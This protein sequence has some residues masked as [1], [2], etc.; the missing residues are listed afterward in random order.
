MIRLAFVALVATTGLLALSSCKV[1]DY[2]LNCGVDD[3]GTGD[4]QG[5]GNGDGNTDGNTG[6]GNGCIN[7]GT[8]VCD[9]KDNDCDGNVDE[10]AL[11]EVGDSCGNGVGECAGGVK[12]CVAGAIVC[13]KNPKPEECN[14]L[15]DDCDGVIDNGD[16][17]GG[18]KC[19]TDQG[20]CSTGTLHCNPTSHTVTCGID[21]GTANAVGCPVGGEM[22]PFGSAE[23]CNG[24]DDDCD[25][26]FDEDV[27]VLGSCSG[28]PLAGDPDA[29]ECQVG[30]LVCDGA[31]GTKCEAIPGMPD[32]QG[33]TFDGCDTKDNDCD[34][35]TDE[36]FHL[37]T[38]PT[39][40]GMCGMV[41]NLPHAFEGCS[42]GNC[43]VLGCEDT[44]HDNDGIAS[45]GCEFGP[46]TI[47]SSV[48]LCNGIDDDCNPATDENNLPPPANLC[49]TLGACAG[50]TAS[51]QGANGFQC[52]YSSDVQT[53]GSGNVVPETSCDGIDNDCD[54][55]IDEGQ[56][57]LDQAC[58]DGET[59]VCKGTGTFQCDP[60]NL[61]GPAICVITD[62]GSSQAPAET[63]DGLDNDCDGK[64]D[65]GADTGNLAGQEWVSI[66]GGG[67]VEIMKYE[68]SQ[69][70]AT[71]T[72][73]GT[74]TNFACSKPNVL[75]WSNVTYPQADAACA[76]IGARLCTEAE[77]QSMCMPRVTY[78]VSGPATAD[79]TDFTFIEA[80]DFF[81]NT[82]IGGASQA[83][84]QVSP[85]AFNGTTFMQV[86]DNGFSVPLIS[87]ALTDSSRL[88]YQ[89]DLE[90]GTDYFIWA[91]LRSPSSSIIAP[92]LGTATAAT[93][94]LAPVSDASTGVGDLVIVVT[95]TRAGNGVPTH[96]LQSGF[97]QVATQGHDDG[98]NDGRFSIAFTI[99][100][101]AG[102]QSYQAYTSSSGTS[103]SGL[104][105]VRAGTFNA[106]N[107]AATLRDRGNSNA[108]N[109]PTSPNVSVDSVAFAIGAW[110]LSSTTTVSVS[111][112]NGFTEL[113]EMSGSNDAELSV[114]S[115]TLS[116]GNVDPGSFGD[117]TGS[118]NGTVAASLVVSGTGGSQSMYVGLTPG[119][120]AGAPST[121]LAVSASN[122]SQWRVTS[123]FTT[124]AAGTYTLSLF[125]REDG[126]LVDTIA[127]SRQG[128]NGPTLDNAWA[129]QSNPRTPQDLTCNADPLDT[130][131]NAGNGDQDDILATGSL[132]MCFANQAGT[133]DAFDMSGNVKEWTQA[134]SP[135]QNPLRGGASNNEVIGTTCQLNFSLA[136]DNFFFPNVGFRC[137]RGP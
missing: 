75:P 127:V 19:G 58:D 103:Y 38:D 30:Q 86:P 26:N 33:P 112:P 28:G 68:A 2:C 120:T 109:P 84:T 117:N 54:G 91:R 80:E 7:T 43:T 132:P 47:Q 21:C 81:A 136:D 13:S 115:A 46:C 83:W 42:S 66:P 82:P 60:N 59:G 137:C 72:S 12:Q 133:D 45:N 5:D 34:G 61:N 44:F 130:D 119:T 123:A 74:D 128:T 55:L 48:E 106:A 1:N 27:G 99:A 24:K 65:E 35:N 129:Y 79:V 4:G 49:L 87:D 118:V 71:G 67:G 125:L 11:P 98:N 113:W 17:G 39:N 89:L 78:P 93:Q 40:C 135:G 102:A 85:A 92:V 104:I 10:G 95:W 36:D 8:E 22:A 76:S 88:D 96:T 41:C 50:A 23:T 122:Q 16:P 57:N 56:P 70:D 63:C 73:T 3:A 114:A 62:P 94:T 131:G 15:D 32:P 37:D 69:P 116:N 18:A 100:T 108:P 90:A 124:G 111:A 6:D 29:G 105:V 77:W 20:E 107:I 51:C 110:H 9:D 97:T 134:R 121:T 126:L 64:T 14:N 53:D 52:D 101:T 25:G 31:G